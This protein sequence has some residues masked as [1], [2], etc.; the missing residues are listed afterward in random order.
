MT[1]QTEMPE[2]LSILLSE[3]KWF[4]TADMAM[5]GQ[6]AL[7][8]TKRISTQRHVSGSNPMS[9]ENVLRSKLQALWRALVHQEIFQEV[10]QVPSRGYYLAVIRP[11][12]PL[13]SQ[14]A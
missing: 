8:T 12:Y 6:T 3:M 11:C 1:W 5:H 9:Q 13:T 2:N 7:S 14:T 10:F 4:D